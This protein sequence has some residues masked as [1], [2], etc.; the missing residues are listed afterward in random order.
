MG[1]AVTVAD[2]NAQRLRQLDERFGGHVRTLAANPSTVAEAVRE[3]D[4]PIGAVLIPGASAP[5]VVSEEMVAAMKRGAVIVD[6]SIDQGG[7]IA[8]ARPTTHTHPSYMAHDV[9]HYCVT[10][11]PAAVPRTSTLALSNVTFS[12]VRLLAD[13]GL[14]AAVERDAGL[15]AGVNT[16]AG[17]LTHTAVAAAQARPFV[18]LP[19]LI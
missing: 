14:K 1:A 6:V 9:V 17:Q 13:R 16:H 10:N 5:K 11:M 18:P 12:Y 15:A 19:Q 8:T 2:R 4:L 7:C 3:A